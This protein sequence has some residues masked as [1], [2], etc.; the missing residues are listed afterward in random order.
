MSRKHKERPE[1]ESLG[2][3]SGGVDTHAH[4]DAENY[5]MGLT[6]VLE[7]ARASGLSRIGNVFLGPD[8]YL[9]HRALFADRL[10]VFFF[11]PSTPTTPPGST[12]PGPSVCSTACGATRASG[13][14]A[15]PGWT[16]TGRT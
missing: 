1:P 10:E 11:W 15:R 12:T 4:L 14:W 7:R 5:E 9:E 2:L 3:P 8:A 6:T 13:P 16:S